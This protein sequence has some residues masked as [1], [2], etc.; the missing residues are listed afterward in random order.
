VNEVRSLRKF[1]SNTVFERDIVN[2]RVKLL[3]NGKDILEKPLI[4]GVDKVV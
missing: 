2:L 4:K 3:T 1:D